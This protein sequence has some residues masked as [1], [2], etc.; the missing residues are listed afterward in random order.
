MADA[1]LAALVALVLTVLAGHPLLAELRRRKLGK[2]YTG[3]EP[4]A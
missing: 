1:A 2:S 4:E 3:D